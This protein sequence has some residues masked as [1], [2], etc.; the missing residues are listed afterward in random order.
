MP[1]GGDA[2]ADVNLHRYLDR[3]VL[4]RRVHGLEA[5]ACRAVSCMSENLDPAFSV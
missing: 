1:A 3:V 5:S 2:E 4:S